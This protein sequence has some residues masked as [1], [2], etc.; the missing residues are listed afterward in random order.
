MS[1]D[2]LAQKERNMHVPPIIKAILEGNNNPPVDFYIFDSNDHIRYKNGIDISGHNY[3][4]HRTIDIRNN[5]NGG[6]GYTVTIFNWDDILPSSTMAPKQMKVIKQKDSI[7]SLQGFGYDIMAGDFSNYAID[8]YFIEK[9]VSKIVLKLLDIN[10]EIE[11][12]GKQKN[13]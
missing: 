5:I 4:C 8:I 2:W 7:V 11:Y 10:I 13:P 1:G 9:E 3:D 6:E 12:F